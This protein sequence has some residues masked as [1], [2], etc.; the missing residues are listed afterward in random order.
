MKY[1][2]KPIAID[3][4]QIEDVTP[5]KGIQWVPDWVV[6]AKNFEI[7]DGVPTVDTLEGRLTGNLGDY[8]IRGVRG[9]LYICERTIFEETYDFVGEDTET[10]VPDG[11][12]EVE[13]INEHEDGSATIIVNASN[14]VVKQ[15]ASLGLKQAL[16][17]AANRAMSTEE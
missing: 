5:T 17:E 4:W 3:A 13:S 11:F 15:F 10:H 2:K 12:I 6:E 8:L 7:I 14:D 16:I 1:M 9:E